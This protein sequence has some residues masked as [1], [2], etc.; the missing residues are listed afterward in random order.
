[1]DPMSGKRSSRPTVLSVLRPDLPVCLTVPLVAGTDYV[2][3][4]GVIVDP[5]GT[6]ANC[7]RAERRRRSTI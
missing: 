4:P 3:L 6:C 7:F 2:V 5:S 1:M